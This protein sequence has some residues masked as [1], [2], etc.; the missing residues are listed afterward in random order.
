M[1]TL[2][3]MSIIRQFTYE[4]E[5][6]RINSIGQLLVVEVEDNL[7][8]KAPNGIRAI[9]SSAATQSG[10]IRVS[11]ID[12]AG[13]VRYSSDT[14]RLNQPPLFSDSKNISE[15]NDGIFAK[16]FFLNTSAGKFRLQILYS[17]S[18][19]QNDFT[20]AIR[21]AFFFDVLLFLSSALMAWIAS[22]FM[23][24]PIRM[25]TDAAS[26]VAG[27]DFDVKLKRKTNDAY[28]NLL[29]ALTV[30]AD[31]LRSLTQHMQERIDEATTELVE[32]NARLRE[33][34]NLKSEFVAMV[35]H[36]LRTPL[37]SIIG[38]ARTLKR[39]NMT[40]EKRQ[41]CYAIIERE[42]RTLSALIEEY[43]D[44]S[45]IETGNFS[46]S[47][48]SVS[49][50]Q[51]I[52]ATIKSLPWP[53]NVSIDATGYIPDIEADPKRLKRVLRNIL[54]N[55][56][57]HGGANVSVTIRTK[58]IGGRVQVSIADNGPGIPHDQ[59]TKIFEKFYRCSTGEGGTGLGLTI[60]RAIVEAH[61][62]SIW[63]ESAPQE[64]TIFHIDLPLLHT[65]GE[66]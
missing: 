34:D 27:G 44:I 22:H 12:S 19:T 61:N 2:N 15:V 53:L 64:G 24:K 36:E 28:G 50:P 46:L 48:A 56:R 32:K 21:W 49:L 29:D 63:C 52:A 51:I 62:G 35:S 25:A 13:I 55:A 20:L 10:I 3:R 16:S 31:S 54:E 5:I 7:A 57:N 6:S 33:L 11:I 42:G 18:K 43:L 38:F 40:E 39:V 66:A 23:E 4:R 14:T 45:K 1:M 8:Q 30:M 37:T 26:R 9:L 59:Q 65:F 60:A 47:I 58:L 41:E 17:L